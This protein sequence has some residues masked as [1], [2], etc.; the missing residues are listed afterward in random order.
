M[1]NLVSTKLGVSGL[2]LGTAL[3]TLLGTWTVARA[4]GSTIS[5]CV[6]NS[7][8]VYVIGEGFRRE[9]C[10][11]RDQLLTWNIQGPAGPQGPA[12]ADGAQG[13]Q[14]EPGPQGPQG[15]QGPQGPAGSAGRLTMYRV[16]SPI[17]SVGISETQTAT[18]TCNP[19]DQVISGGFFM[20][21]STLQVLQS[22]PAVTTEA[23]QVEGSTANPPAGILPGLGFIAAYAWCNDLTP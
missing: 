14:G 23:W 18:A 10:R 7:G 16:T 9:D 12:G 5:V 1:K 19:G 4:A 15:E 20:Q 13:P 21:G 11:S 6:R 3:L 2:V 8:A 22:K 17:V